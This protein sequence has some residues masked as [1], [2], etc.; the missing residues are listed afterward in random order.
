MNAFEQETLTQIRS[1][2]SSGPVRIENTHG[3]KQPVKDLPLQMAQDVAPA[4]RGR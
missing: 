3:D 1:T 2:G 4:L